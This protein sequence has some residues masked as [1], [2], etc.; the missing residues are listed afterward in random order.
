MG[1]NWDEKMEPF[2]A[3]PALPREQNSQSANQPDP[4]DEVAKKGGAAPAAGSE[5]ATVDARTGAAAD[6]TAISPKPASQESSFP[7]AAEGGAASKTPPRPPAVLP[8]MTV[9][10]TQESSNLPERYEHTD[11]VSS[12][13]VGASSAQK[14]AN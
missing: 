14:E 10:D 13:K 5:A 1:D 4:R 8:A 3:F 12:I 11:D 9:A 6:T 2:P 7:S